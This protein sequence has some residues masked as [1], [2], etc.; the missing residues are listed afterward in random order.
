MTEQFLDVAQVGAAV[1][2]VR[3]KRMTQCVR[4]NVIPSC[5]DAYVLFNHAAHGTGSYSCSLVVE[6]QRF[7]FTF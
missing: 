6:K 1:E 2:Q 5:A 3:R 4:A 7:R